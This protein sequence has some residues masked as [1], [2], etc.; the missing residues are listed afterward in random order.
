MTEDAARIARMTNSS[1]RHAAHEGKD[2]LKAMEKSSR[3]GVPP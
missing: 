2:V 3:Q 1:I